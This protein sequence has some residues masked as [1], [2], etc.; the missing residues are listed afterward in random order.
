MA[1]DIAYAEGNNVAVTNTETS[2]AV[3][4]GSTTLQT[5][6][7]VGMYMLVLDGVGSLVKGDEY[8]WKVYEKAQSAGTKRV[9]MQGKLRNAQSEPLVLPSLF[10]G[11]G[12]D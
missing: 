2:L 7:D 9:I 4:G 10:L 8:T 5:L 12:W 3:D 11:V 1:F 6:T